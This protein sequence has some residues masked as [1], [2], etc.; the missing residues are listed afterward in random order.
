MFDSLEPIYVHAVYADEDDLAIMERQKAH[1]VHCPV[2]NRLLG[3]GVLDLES[4]KAREIPYSIATDGLSSNFSINIFKEMRASLM[5]QTSLDL[6]LLARDL[7]ISATKNPADALGLKCGS[8]EKGKDADFITIELPNSIENEKSL[9]LQVILHS[10]IVN[11]V[12]IM[13]EKIR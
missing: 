13:G 4:I 10:N 8:I 6:H 9:S 3:G 12:Y 7:L 1:I 11:R 5:Q 2:S